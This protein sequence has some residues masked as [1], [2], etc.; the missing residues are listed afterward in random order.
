ML[1]KQG[2]NVHW[3]AWLLCGTWAE[4]RFFRSKARGQTLNHVSR[5]SQYR[6]SPAGA[7]SGVAVKTRL[8]GLASSRWGRR[9]HSSLKVDIAGTFQRERMLRR[10]EGPYTSLNEC[11]PTRMAKLIFK[12]DRP[13]VTLR[14]G[15][16][17]ANYSSGR[18][19]DP[20]K[21]FNSFCSLS[22]PRDGLRQT[23]SG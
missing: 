3:R 1:W 14:A 20:T 16:R 8:A 23:S 11:A 21:N 22:A 6:P 4:T 5:D 2:A 9:L 17:T 13:Q 19:I 12:P 10:L 7:P 15:A 18:L